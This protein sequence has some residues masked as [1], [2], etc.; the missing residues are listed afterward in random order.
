MKNKI[1]LLLLT[2]SIITTVIYTSISTSITTKSIKEA[3]HNIVKSGI[4]YNED[5]SYT[6]IFKTIVKLTKLDEKDII[7]ALQLDYVDKIITNIIN[8]IYEYNITGNNNV[9]YKKEDIIKLVEDNLEKIANDINYNLKEEDK[10]NIIKY[11]KENIDY[12]L[13]TIYNTNIGNWRPNND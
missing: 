9:K 3:S 12:I 1:L 5:N 6:E 13:N 8:S 10:D 2:I 4:I 11:T 7:K